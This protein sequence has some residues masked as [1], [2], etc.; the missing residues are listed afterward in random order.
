MPQLDKYSFIPQLVWF[1]SIFFLLFLFFSQSVLPTIARSLKLRERVIEGFSA[2]KDVSSSDLEKLNMEILA[3]FNAVYANSN[4]SIISL[5][6]SAKESAKAPDYILKHS[7]LAQGIRQ[8]FL[9]EFSLLRIKSLT[10]S[11]ISK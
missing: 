4:K 2:D 11:A 8:V 5:S 7:K 3:S 6:T 1:F 9:E 10:T